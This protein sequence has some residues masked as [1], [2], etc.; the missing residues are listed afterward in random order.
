MATDGFI[1]GIERIRK[2][3]EGL[4]E[5]PNIEEA[6]W[7][8]TNDPEFWVLFNQIEQAG[9]DCNADKA[10]WLVEFTQIDDLGPMGRALF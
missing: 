1:S 7:D 3:V 2:A 5:V 4:A 10:P 9:I 6:G 8:I